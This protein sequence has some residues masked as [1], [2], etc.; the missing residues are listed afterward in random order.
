[1]KWQAGFGRRHC[2]PDRTDPIA[3]GIRMLR[4]YLRWRHGTR[5]HDRI[6]ALV[7]DIEEGLT[8]RRE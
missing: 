6:H 4:Q 1:M 8:E 3:G 5:L 2:Q 7:S